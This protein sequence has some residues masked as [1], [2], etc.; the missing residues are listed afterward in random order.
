MQLKLDKKCVA[1]QLMHFTK[2]VNSDKN[3]ITTNHLLT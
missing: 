1:D 3:D 2:Q